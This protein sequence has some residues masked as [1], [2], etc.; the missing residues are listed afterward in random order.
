MFFLLIII[1]QVINVSK[2]VAEA[3]K[4][5]QIRLFTAALIASTSPLYELQT[6]EQPWSVASSGN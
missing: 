4:Y 2:A 6:V 5:P 3:D 1:D